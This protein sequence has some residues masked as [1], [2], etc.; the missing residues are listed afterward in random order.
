LA[1]GF[2]LN[3]SCVKKYHHPFGVL[4]LLH[5]ASPKRSP[6]PLVPT[7]HEQRPLSHTPAHGSGP[8]QKTSYTVFRSPATQFRRNKSNRQR[9][10]PQSRDHKQPCPHEATDQSNSGAFQE[11]GCRGAKSGEKIAPLCAPEAM[12]ASRRTVEDGG[13]GGGGGTRTRGGS[14]G[15]RTGGGGREGKRVGRQLVLSLRRAVPVT[16]GEVIYCSNLVYWPPCP[17]GR[18]VRMRV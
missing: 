12:A 15:R 17:C 6:F 5:G 11:Q 9:N 16:S 7:A 10:R 3:N 13:G 1:Y 8:N 4:L 14:G 18:L 2:H